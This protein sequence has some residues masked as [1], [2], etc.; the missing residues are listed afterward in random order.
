VIF[1][2]T[3]FARLIGALFTIRWSMIAMGSSVG[4]TWLPLKPPQQSYLGYFSSATL[5]KRINS[6]KIEQKI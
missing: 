5:S 3:G 6:K 4:F 2:L 1:K